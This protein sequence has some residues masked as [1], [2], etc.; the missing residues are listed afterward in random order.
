MK[1]S[2]FMLMDLHPFTKYEVKMVAENTVGSSKP[3]K[4]LFATTYEDTPSA[5]PT[6]VQ[7]YVDD[8]QQVIV[9]WHPIQLNA[10]NGVI[11]GYQVNG[12]RVFEI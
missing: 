2:E 8:R 11:V 12:N 6:D 10:S 1:S 5:A 3:T 7:A 9:L 4:S